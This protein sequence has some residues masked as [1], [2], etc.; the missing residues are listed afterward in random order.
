LIS[1]PKL[2]AIAA[3]GPRKIISTAQSD[4]QTPVSGSTGQ[5]EPLSLH[6]VPTTKEELNSTLKQLIER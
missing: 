1:L 5:F 4:A 3:P 2:G 6:L